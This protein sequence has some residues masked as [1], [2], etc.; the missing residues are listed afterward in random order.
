M[1]KKRSFPMRPRGFGTG[2]G[3]CLVCGNDDGKAC[4]DF[5]SFVPTKQTGESIVSLIKAMGGHSNLDYRPSEPNWIQVK[6]CACPD[7][8][9]AL[10][11]L[12]RSV[13]ENGSVDAEKVK[14]SLKIKGRATL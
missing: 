10:E 8:T 2:W 9:K 5:A 13:S 1:V 3:K 4:D 7:H 6:I 14:N 12:Y 11:H